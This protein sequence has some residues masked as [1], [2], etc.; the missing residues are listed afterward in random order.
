MRL[1]YLCVEPRVYGVYCTVS[2]RSK[3]QSTSLHAMATQEVL[4]AGRQE[5]EALA[6]LQQ[7]LVAARFFCFITAE[8]GRSSEG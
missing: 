6:T 8:K 7:T 5:E 3:R 4:D 2:R 1:Q